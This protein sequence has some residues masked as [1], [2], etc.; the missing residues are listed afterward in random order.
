MRKIVF[1]V[2]FM[3]ALCAGVYGQYS[4]HGRISDARSGISLPGATVYMPDLNK[5]TTSDTSGL[6]RLSGLP[7]NHLLTEFQYIGYASKILYINPSAD[8]V[9]VIQLVPQVTEMNEV[10]ITGSSRPTE[11]VRSPVISAILDRDALVSGSYSNPVEAVTRIPGVALISTGNAIAKPVIRGLGYNRVVTL[12]N[13]VR[14]EGQQWGDEHGIEMDGNIVGRVEV[15]KGPGSLMYGSDAMAGVINFL[16]P[17]PVAEG[18]SGGEVLTQYRINGNSFE[19]SWSLWG[20][21]KGLVWSIRNTEVISGNYSDASDGKVLNSGYRNICGSGM[22]GINR[23]WGYSHL[24]AE[25]FNQKIGFVTGERDSLGHWLKNIPSGDSTVLAVAGSSDLNGYS[26]FLPFQKINHNRLTWLT[27]L[28]LNNRSILSLNIAFQ[29]NRRREFEDEKANPNLY[30]LLNTLTYDVRYSLGNQENTSLT[31]GFSG[32]TQ[33]GKNKSHERLIPDHSLTDAG[34]YAMLDKKWTSVSFSG[35]MRYDIRLLDTKALYEDADENLSSSPE[36]GYLVKFSTIR[37]HY[38]N[39]SGSAGFTWQPLPGMAM[40]INAAR[41]YRAPNL[42]ELSCNGVHEGTMQYETGNASLKS[43]T[44]FQT[45]MALMYQAEHIAIEL[46]LF[47]NAIQHF[48]YSMKLEGKNG[49]DS[50]SE[51]LPVYQYTQGSALLTGGEFSIDLH[52][53][54][55]DWIHFQNTVSWVNSLILHQPDSARYLPYTPPVRFTS[56]LKAKSPV[57]FGRLSNAFFGINF[58]H[59]FRQDHVLLMAGT[60]TPT[61]AYSLW[62]LSLGTDWLGKNGHRVCSLAINLENAF[63]VAYFDHLSRMKYI[64]YN[65]QDNRTGIYNPGRNLSFRLTVPIGDFMKSK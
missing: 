21:R 51:G 48:I 42:A 55:Y 36:P 12:F 23:N 31:F 15:I 34:M 61:A 10:V 43:E 35:G 44:S 53:H 37:H 62:G 19:G 56:E 29:Q 6:F 40:K 30:M 17:V 9:L 47:R 50:L 5:G 16:P 45:D 27:N 28:T 26:I 54:P 65:P 4:I 1:I 7:A 49:T 11:L 14:Q 38:G 32:M 33:A 13:G 58:K 18:V 25:S 59:C 60:E 46:D 41:G 39:V 24:Y 22:V 8:S 2:L 57:D 64:G 63:D 20:N 52:P 3:A